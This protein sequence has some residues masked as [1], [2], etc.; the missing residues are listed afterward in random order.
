LN[1]IALT[2]VKTPAYHPSMPLFR[3]LLAALFLL[4]AA[5]LSELLCAAEG[6]CEQA[7]A[8]QAGHA[9][10]GAEH[11][12]EGD[13]ACEWHCLSCGAQSVATT[14]L[15]AAF[16]PVSTLLELRSTP[17]AFVPAPPCASIFHPPA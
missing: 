7:C 2:P 12:D 5:G 6:G 8:A 3:A 17:L 10:E 1:R 4:Q 14:S 15:Q 11:D 13:A 16:R 9:D